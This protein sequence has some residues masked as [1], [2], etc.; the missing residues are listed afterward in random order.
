LG[1]VEGVR[2][3][4]AWSAREHSLDLALKEHEV[5]LGD[6]GAARHVLVAAEQFKHG[7]IG[8]HGLVWALED[9][10]VQ[11]QEVCEGEVEVS[12]DGWVKRVDWQCRDEAL[13]TPAQGVQLKAVRAT[14]KTFSS[15]TL[16]AWCPG[17]E[18][19]LLAIALQAIG[20]PLPTGSARW[21]QDARAQAVAVLRLLC[22]Q[23]GSHASAGEALATVHDVL[24]GRSLSLHVTH[25][26][27]QFER[28]PV[29]AR[30][31]PCCLNASR[32]AIAAAGVDWT[33]PPEAQA[34]SL[35][36]VTT[37]RRAW[38]TSKATRA[39]LS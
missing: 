6:D 13:D 33:G 11:P 22:R 16:A 26:P 2:P 38:G 10:K 19:T 21:M 4:P 39:S 20:R 7:V 28:H 15:A 25:S 37:A 9:C 30:E 3:C 31:A 1:A 29:S 27:G 12:V 23:A 35:R 24:Q 18:T 34:H 8:G 5:A 17:G 36:A 32:N 14:I